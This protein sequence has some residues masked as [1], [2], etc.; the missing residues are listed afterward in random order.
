M[1][2]QPNKIKAQNIVAD[3]RPF[4]IEAQQTLIELQASTLKL[5]IKNL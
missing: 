5:K 2:S 4:E 1:N 3:S